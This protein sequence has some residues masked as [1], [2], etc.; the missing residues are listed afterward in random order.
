MENSNAPKSDFTGRFLETAT[1]QSEILTSQIGTL[2]EILPFIWPELPDFDRVRESIK[3]AMVFSSQISSLLHDSRLKLRRQSMEGF[4][5]IRPEPSLPDPLD[6]GEK[7]TRSGK[8]SGLLN[9]DRP[10][11]NWSDGKSKRPEPSDRKSDFDIEK[12]E[13]VLDNWSAADEVFRSHVMKSDAT[14]AP[15]IPV[16]K[17]CNSDHENT[18]S[19]SR[20]KAEEEGGQIGALKPEA[21]QEGGRHNGPPDDPQMRAAALTA[22]REPREERPSL[23]FDGRIKIAPYLTVAS[24]KAARSTNEPFSLAGLT[25]QEYRR[26]PPKGKAPWQEP[27]SFPNLPKQESQPFEP[28]LSLKTEKRIAKR[29][30]GAYRI[31][32]AETKEK[33]IKLC[34]VLS[35]K[36]TAEALNVSQKSVKR[37]MR[38]GIERVRDP[39]R[40]RRHST[41]ENPAANFNSTVNPER[42]SAEKVEDEK[43]GEEG[44]AGVVPAAEQRGARRKHSKSSR[45]GSEAHGPS[46]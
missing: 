16:L 45:A 38:H 20:F 29:R 36:K 21:F 42:A 6:F 33:A 4:V 11:P 35:I 26:L 1:R 13:W 44:P 10:A 39:T 34:Q 25:F 46:A 9:P 24:P 17:R 28:D 32:P 43:G 30:R 19:C 14:G 8:N 15:P 18:Q 31:C 2:S 37:W 40:V 23:S 7:I 12:T 22:P 27:L 3:E 5:R 41:A